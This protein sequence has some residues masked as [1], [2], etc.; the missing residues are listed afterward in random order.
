MFLLFFA[1]T[2][3]T[4]TKIISF[5]NFDGNSAGQQQVEERGQADLEAQEKRLFHFLFV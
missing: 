4:H 2:T 5:I 3:S 1:I